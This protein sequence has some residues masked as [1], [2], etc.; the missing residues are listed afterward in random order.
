MQTARLNCYSSRPTRLLIMNVL[1][2]IHLRRFSVGAEKAL[3]FQIDSEYNILKFANYIL[4][5][6]NLL[7]ACAKRF[8]PVQLTSHQKAALL[9]LLSPA[10]F[11]HEQSCCLK[12]QFLLG[13]CCQLVFF[14]RPRP[15]QCFQ[16]QDKTQDSGSK[17][18]PR[19][20]LRP[21][22]RLKHRLFSK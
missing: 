8:H 16:D 19:S 21:I 9:C 6:V 18:R 4:F 14:S 11:K 12:Q 20:F 2:F 17:T 1:Y 5:N 15:A 3:L 13:S 7:H 22:S 10:K